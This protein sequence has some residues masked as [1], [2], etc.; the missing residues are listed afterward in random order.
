MSE[1]K[2]N[3]VILARYKVPAANLEKVKA[4]L[5]EMQFLSL[6]EEG[7]LVYQPH[8][9]VEDPCTIVLYEVYKDDAAINAHRDSDHFQTIALGQIVPLLE[10]RAVEILSQ[11]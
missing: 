9:T 1:A 6:Q 7:C 10:S 3:R 4:L 2:Q 11:F 5:Q 8:Q